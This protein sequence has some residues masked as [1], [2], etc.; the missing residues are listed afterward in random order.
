ME[1]V[2][3]IYSDIICRSRGCITTT[4]YL[5]DTGEFTTINDNL[6]ILRSSLII[7][8]CVISLWSVWFI[9]SQVTTTINTKYIVMCISN[10]FD[11]IVKGCFLLFS[12]TTACQGTRVCSIWSCIGIDACFRSKVRQFLTIISVRSVILCGIVTQLVELLVL[13][14]NRNN[15]CCTLTLRSI[16]MNQDMSLRCTIKVITTEDAFY[17]TTFA[18]CSLAFIQLHSSIS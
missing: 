1:F 5:F 11:Q 4:I 12:C 13:T 2:G 6:C 17:T 3:C 18:T 8:F 15:L 9:H 7:S 10:Q 16:Y 14:T